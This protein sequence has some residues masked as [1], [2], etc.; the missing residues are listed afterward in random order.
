MANRY[1]GYDIIEKLK[2]IAS[3]PTNGINA[4]IS[5]I[6]AER[7]L[8][9]PNI[10]T[11][12]EVWDTR[13]LP[14]MFIDIE[15]SQVLPAEDSIGGGGDTIGTRNVMKTPEVYSV[16][17]T[18][19]YKSP[20]VSLNKWMELYGEA[21]YRLYHN[22]CDENIIWIVARESARAEINA[23]DNQTAKTVGYKFD[24]RIDRS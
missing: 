24:L 15:S 21:I 22:Y 6:N 13:F 17:I 8:T 10:M 11:I 12:T 1:F 3:D 23:T 4:I 9:L 18:I 7:T 5:T 14:I 2:T 19:T 20:D 16:Y